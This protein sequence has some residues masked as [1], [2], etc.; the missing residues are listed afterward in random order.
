MGKHLLVRELL[1]KGVAKEVIQEVLL[2]TFSESERELAERLL[3]SRRKRM[4]LKDP[5]SYG[6]L[7][8]FLRRRG[9]AHELVSELL[10]KD[11][12]GPYDSE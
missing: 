7:Y 3:A 1:S 9:F 4:D 2:Q 10:E 11:V 8:G 5:A 6:K 12:S